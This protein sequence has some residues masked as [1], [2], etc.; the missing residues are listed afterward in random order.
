MQ[1]PMNRP[2]T[3]YAPLVTDPGARGRFD[4]RAAGDV[5]AADPRWLKLG[6]AAAL[7]LVAGTM[8]FA[9]EAHGRAGAR[10]DR[11]PGRR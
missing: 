6:I 9:T 11:R 2:D 7:G 5:A 4:A 1:A 8:L 10:T 3:L